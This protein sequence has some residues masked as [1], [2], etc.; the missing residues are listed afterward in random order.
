MLF[1]RLSHTPI[2]PSMAALG[3]QDMADPLGIWTQSSGESA[4]FKF[5][6][7]SLGI[8]I[9]LSLGVVDGQETEIAT[10]RHDIVLKGTESVFMV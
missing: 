9:P 10:R 4:G 1:Y 2:L 8:L 7:D 3:L 5:I 6:D